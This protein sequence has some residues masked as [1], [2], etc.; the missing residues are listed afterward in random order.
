[1]HH[2]FSILA[3]QQ[4]TPGRL[5]RGEDPN[6]RQKEDQEAPRVKVEQLDDDEVVDSASEEP[7]APKFTLVQAERTG[8]DC[9]DFSE[10]VRNNQRRMKK[11]VQDPFITLR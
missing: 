11:E 1:M 3:I 7:K 2:S 4:E 9:Y 8:F 6:E 5:V 10:L